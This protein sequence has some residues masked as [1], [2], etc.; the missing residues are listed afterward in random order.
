MLSKVG[1]S[2]VGQTAFGTHF[3]PLHSVS[4]VQSSSSLQVAG[5]VASAGATAAS[6]VSLASPGAGFFPASVEPSASGPVPWFELP[7]AGSAVATI[8][9]AATAERSAP[10]NGS[11]S[12][13]SLL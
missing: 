9:I 5:N 2:P 10:F 6:F 11:L 3:P 12:A 8:Q 13:S 4:G 7:Q 1:S